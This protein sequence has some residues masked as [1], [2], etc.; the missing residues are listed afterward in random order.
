MKRVLSKI[1]LYLMI[2]AGTMSCTG[3]NLY[4]D[5][6]SNKNTDDALYEDAQKLL[7]NGNYSGA[8][9]KILSTSADF[10][11]KSR[12]KE[13]LAGAYASR[14][15]M[16][17]LT[18]VTNLTNGTST[19]FFKLALNGFVGVD[20]SNYA[21]CKSA[22]ALI[23]GI[24]P[25]GSR[26]QS[27]NIFLWFLEM[28]KI[29]NRMRAVGDSNPALGDGTVDAGF[30]CRTSVPIADAQEVIESFSKF[31]VLFAAVGAT[32]SGSSITQIQSFITQYGASIPTTFDYSGGS[33]AGVDEFDPAIIV[34]RAL[35]NMQSMGLGSCAN[36]D[37]SQ[38][39]CP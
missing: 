26:T 25:I 17:F 36:P 27:Q 4:Q 28:A 39:I 24:G 10:Q 32:V 37:P 29:G 14:C 11:T 13:T 23:E 31:I 22:E 7:D 21:D 15:G 35:I 34:S 5:L 19:S 20:T 9:T 38:C 33:G 1:S 16:V 12:V 2:T 6:S 8:I 3:A 18:F 30:N